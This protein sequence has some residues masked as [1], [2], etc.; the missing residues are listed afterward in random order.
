M[1]HNKIGHPL[2]GV[3]FLNVMVSNIHI[4][5]EVVLHG[6]QPYCTKL[7]GI[8]ATGQSFLWVHLR[9]KVTLFQ[10]GSAFLSLWLVGFEQKN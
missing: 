10:K 3:S 5:I 4:R 1:L 6:L 7:P 2:A 8:T 9:L